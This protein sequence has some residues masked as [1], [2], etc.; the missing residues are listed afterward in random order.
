MKDSVPRHSLATDNLYVF[1][2]SD[3]LTNHLHN[4]VKTKG[5]EV[6]LSYD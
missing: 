2:L 4:S 1:D 6:Q 3:S 5:K